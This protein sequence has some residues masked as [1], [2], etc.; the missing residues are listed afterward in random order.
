MERGLARIKYLAPITGEEVRIEM[1]V[2]EQYLDSKSSLGNTI[3]QYKLLNPRF[4]QGPVNTGFTAPVFW[5][6]RG[7]EAIVP[8]GITKTLSEPFLAVNPFESVLLVDST[9]L[10]NKDF[11]LNYFQNRMHFIGGSLKQKPVI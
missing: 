9:A 10:S 1:N 7:Q 8:W 3:I 5:F 4:I 11:V 6:K 2:Q